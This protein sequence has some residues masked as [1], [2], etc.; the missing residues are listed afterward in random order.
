[1]DYDAHLKG[2]KKSYYESY[3]RQRLSVARQR[4][5]NPYD[6][7]NL[8]IIYVSAVE[9]F[10]RSLV[11]W[12]ETS[13]ER[14]AEETYNKFKMSGVDKL[15]VEFLKQNNLS[16]EKIISDEIYRLVKYAVEYRNLL[17]HECTYLGQDTFPDL[18]EACQQFLHCLSSHAGLKR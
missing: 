13:G 11:I 9:G 5:E 10:L 7:P 14:P 17:A 1:M 4:I 16:S 12:G 18:I 15:Y 6:G 8:L 3:P 2:L